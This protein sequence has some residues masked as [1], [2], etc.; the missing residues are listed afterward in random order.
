MDNNG[1]FFD[2]LNG[3]G[4]IIGLAP[5]VTVISAK[6][7]GKTSKLTVYVGGAELICH[8]CRR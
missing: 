1:Y 6:Y 7:A 5:G 3:N 2:T 8:D 4:E